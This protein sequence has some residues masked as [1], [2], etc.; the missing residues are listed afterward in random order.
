MT[1]L[2]APAGSP[3]AVQAALEAGADHVYVGL[4]GWSRGG[5]R[6][7]L[8]WRELADVVVRAQARGAEVQVALNTIP[9][10]RERAELFAHVPR[11]AAL[12]IRTLIVNDLGILAALHRR[13]PE[14]RL[15]ASIGCGAQS[16]ADVAFFAE[17]GAAAV[18]LPG[19]VGPAEAAVCAAVPG[20]TVEIMLHMVEEFV[21][22]GKCWMP[23]Y[24]HLRPTALPGGM[25]DAMRQTGSM[26]RGGVG[27]C[28]RICQEPWEL[29]ADGGR[30]EHPRF[31]SRQLSR[32]GDVAEYVAAG[33]GVL[34][35]QGR[36]LPPE[37]LG[38]LVRRYRQAL[39]AA[40]TG[41]PVPEGP[42]AA[43]P[44]SWTVLG[45]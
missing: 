35:L 6:G 36:S 22:L 37:P 43:L 7:E 26:K 34:K 19:T 11:V 12:G 1:T 31:P 42:E 38:S 39:D 14:L 44:P 27:A 13:F 24:V 30:R 4:K 20:I 2:L 15:T 33:V 21:L 25:P 8:D 18:V 23:S 40:R 28:F 16:D 45:R 9:K 17:I 32:V 3:E 41:D 5:A 29:T 10:P